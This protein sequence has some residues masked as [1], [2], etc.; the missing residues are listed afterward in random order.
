MNIQVIAEHSVDMDLL[1]D[2]SNII[3]GGCRGFEFTDYF[4]DLGHNV[5]AFDIDNFPGKNYYMTAITGSAGRVGIKR[6]ADKNAT[7]VCD[8]ND[9]CSES[10]ENITKI[11]HITMWDLIKLDIEGSEYEVIMSMDRPYATQL[12]IEF[13]A[14]CAYDLGTINIMVK[15]LESLGYEAVQHTVD[16]RHGLGLNAWDSLFILKSAL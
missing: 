15:K 1:P 6:S 10:I 11:C 16:K 3:D 12:T 2:R 14:H 8:G 4:R 13:H 7:K 9:V 5:R